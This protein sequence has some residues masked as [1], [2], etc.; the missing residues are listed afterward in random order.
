MPGKRLSLDEI[1]YEK[2]PYILKLSLLVV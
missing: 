2:P 1:V